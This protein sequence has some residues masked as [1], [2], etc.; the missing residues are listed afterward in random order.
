MY[1]F[2]IEGASMCIYLHKNMYAVG[3]EDEDVNIDMCIFMNGSPCD[4]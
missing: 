1:W 4:C 3:D 2:L